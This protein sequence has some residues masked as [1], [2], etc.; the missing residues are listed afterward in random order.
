MCVWEQQ[1]GNGLGEGLRRCRGDMTSGTSQA[2]SAVSKAP[3]APRSNLSGDSKTREKTLGKLR[4]PIWN[5][6]SLISRIKELTG[7]HRKKSLC[8]RETTWNE[9]KVKENGNK[10]KML[11]TEKTS[12][13]NRVGV[14]WDEAMETKVMKVIKKIECY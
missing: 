6:G 2:A 13:R 10:Y 14:I 12:R 4:V 5:V 8:T 7:I 11:Y 9:D 3:P 1:N